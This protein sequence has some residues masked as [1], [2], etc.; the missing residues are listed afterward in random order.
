MSK[1]P[2]TMNDMTSLSTI[3]IVQSPYKERFGIPRQ[4]G[5]VNAQGALIMQADY[6]D[7]IMLDGLQDFSHIWVTFLFHANIEQGWKKKVRPPRLGGK[8]QVGVF[9]SRSPHRP[10]FLGLSV[11]KLEAV[12]TEKPV[13]LKVSGLDLLD[14]TPI[15]D[16]KPYVAYVDAIDN[17][18]S[19]YARHAPSPAQEVIFTDKVLA[20]L[21]NRPD[22]ETDKQ[23]I[24]DVLAQDPRPAYKTKR[25]TKRDFGML[26]ADDEVKW[27]VE[28][29]TTYVTELKIMSA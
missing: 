13:Q 15:V 23:L 10:N 20:V 8:K 28:G 11:L 14:G 27:R 26:L 18:N 1:N 25:L 12:Q 4:P 19:G 16:I 17:A 5:L 21:N 29:G 24:H 6:D 9:A 22:A 7:P 3:A 2:D